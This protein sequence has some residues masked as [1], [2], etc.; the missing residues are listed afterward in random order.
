[1]KSKIYKKLSP[2]MY[3]SK[4]RAKP[5]LQLQLILCQSFLNWISWCLVYRL[6]SSKVKISHYFL[7]ISFSLKLPSYTAKSNLV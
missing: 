3:I 7:I 4:Y 2:L 5:S 1:M 6:Q